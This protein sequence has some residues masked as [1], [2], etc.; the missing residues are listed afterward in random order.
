M[1]CV[2]IITK[3]YIRS[4]YSSVCNYHI[5][6]CIQTITPLDVESIFLLY[7]ILDLTANEKRRISK[8]YSSLSNLDVVYH[9]TIHN[10]RCSVA[11]IIHLLHPQ[12]HIGFF[13]F[14]GNIFLFG[15]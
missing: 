6:L 10:F 14:F 3:L 9:F 4:N 15:K 2:V 13:E 8:R 12:H 1:S 11:D 5:T 7:Y